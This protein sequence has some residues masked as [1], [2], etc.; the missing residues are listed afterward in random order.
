M[1]TKKF[2]KKHNIHSG[3]LDSIATNSSKTINDDTTA[4]AAGMPEG[5]LLWCNGKPT[6]FIHLNALVISQKKI[7]SLD[8]ILL[9]KWTNPFIFL[10]S[11]FFFEFNWK[12]KNTKILKK[13]T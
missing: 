6:F 4:T 11:P 12:K 8:P 3:K 7:I 9:Y 13:S 10:G 1:N 2:V 5:N